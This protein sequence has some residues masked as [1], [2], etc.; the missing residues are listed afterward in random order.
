[1]EAA[2]K[3]LGLSDPEVAAAFVT[4]AREMRRRGALVAD[5]RLNIW[6]EAFRLCDAEDK[7]ILDELRARLNDMR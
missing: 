2:T 6:I 5:D 1:M 7:A 3:R 4:V